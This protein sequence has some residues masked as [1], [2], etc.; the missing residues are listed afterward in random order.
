MERAR[1]GRTNR[2]AYDGTSRAKIRR[3]R[4]RLGFTLQELAGDAG[5]SKPYLSLI[6][7]GRMP[8]PPSDEKLRRLEQVLGFQAGE[9]IT[10]AHLH[11]T[12][13]DV[14]AA[15]QSLLAARHAVSLP[16]A[17]GLPG[18][19]RK[20][21]ER[22]PKPGPTGG[23]ANFRLWPEKSRRNPSARLTSPPC[24][25]SWLVRKSRPSA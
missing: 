11:R 25:R 9:L 13:R 10:H 2:G 19:R 3:Q 16:D 5:I 6:E 24:T 15:L 23:R 8:N 17:A 18:A 21:T 14:R 20:P 22:R 1:E 7:T 12:P 4:L